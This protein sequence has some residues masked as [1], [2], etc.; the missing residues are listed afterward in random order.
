MCITKEVLTTPPRGDGHLYS[1]A[2]FYSSQGN[3]LSAIQIQYGPSPWF[4]LFRAVQSM[5]DTIK[6]VISLADAAVRGI[7]S[8]GRWTNT[9]ITLGIKC[10]GYIDPFENH[11][12][13]ARTFDGFISLSGRQSKPRSPKDPIIPAQTDSASPNAI[14]YALNKFL[15]RLP[16][17]PNSPSF[18]SQG[19]LLPPLKQ[20]RLIAERLPPPLWQGTGGYIGV[21][22]Y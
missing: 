6:A 12:T 10:Y 17:L 13:S 21:F 15:T 14:L 5:V 20:E 22:R 7:S 19:C 9:A 1:L 3:R 8:K 11:L 18:G 16:G 2:W 4:V